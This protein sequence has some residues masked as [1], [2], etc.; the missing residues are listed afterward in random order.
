MA[1][2]RR[3]LVSS[4]FCIKVA[5]RGSASQ[6]RHNQVL[7]A[8]HAAT[9]IHTATLEE[10][11]EEEDDLPRVDV[12]SRIP[13]LRFACCAICV[14]VVVFSHQLLALVLPPALPPTP[15]LPPP[16]SLPR[17]QTASTSE[18]SLVPSS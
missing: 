4:G 8:T 7:S 10:E 6:P 2:V 14:M 18:T 3:L 1:E 9:P 12:K 13:R 5:A 16:L 11:E 17:L 15:P